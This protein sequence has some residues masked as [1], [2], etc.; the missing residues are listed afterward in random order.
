MRLP[1]RVVTVSACHRKSHLLGPRTQTQ[2]VAWPLRRVAGCGTS[3]TS[4][5]RWGRD[6][7]R[8][9]KPVLGSG[10]EGETPGPSIR[11]GWVGDA[12]HGIRQGLEARIRK[13]SRK[14]WDRPG[15]RGSLQKQ[16]GSAAMHIERPLAKVAA[17][18]GGWRSSL[19]TGTASAVLDIRCLFI[20]V[21][22]LQVVSPCRT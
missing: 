3:V 2:P 10:I 14:A 18:N 22:P 16:R 7:S 21:M 11:S 6:A 1:Q 12:Q 20:C 17:R 13:L 9:R 5:A 19:A 15:W 8:Y 4:K